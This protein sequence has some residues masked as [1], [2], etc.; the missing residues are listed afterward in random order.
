MN[1]KTVFYL[2]ERDQP[3]YRCPICELLLLHPSCLL[4][5]DKE[6]ARYLEH[7]NDINDSGYQEFVNPLFQEICKNVKPG[8]SGL[9]FGSG[10]GPVL[11]HKLGQKA[12][13]IRL[14]DPFFHPDASAL[15]QKYDFVAACEVV[16]HLHAPRKEFEL[17][18]SILNP[19][20]LLAVM[21]WLWD[22]SIDFANWGYRRDSA[23]VAFYS[24]TTFKW[25]AANLGFS[26][27]WFPHY[28]IALLR[29]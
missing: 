16:E 5:P 3:Y 22:E 24:Q 21:T 13:P 11:A 10:T 17:L 9:D 19:G 25:I 18:R 14:F 7:I 28:R 4:T 27:V 12:Y 29:I 6:K 20:G 2:E 26:K 15:S 23:H 8:A 1:P